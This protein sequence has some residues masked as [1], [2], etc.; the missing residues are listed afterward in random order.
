VQ[1]FSASSGLAANLS[2]GQTG[3][4]DGMG[5]ASGSFSFFGGGASND[6]SA[7]TASRRRLAIWLARRLVGIA[8][9]ANSSSNTT[10]KDV[11]N[12]N[13]FECLQAGGGGGAESR[14]GSRAQ[15]EEENAGCEHVPDA[16]VELF[17]N[18][19][20]FFIAI[21]V[22]F[23]LQLL[24]LTYWKKRANRAY[25]EQKEKAEALVRRATDRQ[26]IAVS[27]AIDA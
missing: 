6:D 24:V 9:N 5:W 11:I 3:V 15:S 12:L 8:G 19:L 21:P 22:I 10:I 4:A 18:L 20:S 27:T 1:R 17:K 7:A 25:Y 16:L 13:F 2:K 26:L 14:Q 23:L